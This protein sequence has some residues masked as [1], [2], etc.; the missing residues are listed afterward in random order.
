MQ[1]RESSFLTCCVH[2]VVSFAHNLFGLCSESTFFHVHGGV[3]LMFVCGPALGVW[4]GAVIHVCIV[5]VHKVRNMFGT[6][7]VCLFVAAVSLCTVT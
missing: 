7:L 1:Y 4:F 3:C 6:L 2:V 5:S